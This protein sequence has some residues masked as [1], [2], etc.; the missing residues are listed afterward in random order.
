LEING[1]VNRTRTIQGSAF[2]ENFK[3]LNKIITIILEFQKSRF[4]EILSKGLPDF[5]IMINFVQALLVK[6][7]DFKTNDTVNTIPE[8]SPNLQEVQGSTYPY[9]NTYSRKRLGFYDG[10]L[11]IQIN[12]V[13]KSLYDFLLFY[14]NIYVN[15]DYFDVFNL[16]DDS[17]RDADFRRNL[18]LNPSSSVETF[19]LIVTKT[20][21]NNILSTILSSNNLNIINQIIQFFSTIRKNILELFYKIY[22][23]PPQTVGVRVSRRVA[24][25][26]FINIKDVLQYFKTLEGL[27]KVGNDIIIFEQTNIVDYL[28]HTTQTLYYNLLTQ[29]TIPDKVLRSTL[30]PPLQA[31]LNKSEEVLADESIFTIDATKDIEEDK[32]SLSLT[33]PPQPTTIAPPQVPPSSLITDSINN[34]SSKVIKKQRLRE[35]RQQQQ[36]DKAR[37]TK[38]YYTRLQVAKNLIGSYV[39]S[40]NI[41]RKIKPNVAGDTNRSLG[42]LYEITD[43]HLLVALKILFKREVPYLT[44]IGI[45]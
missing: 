35:E 6:L 32:R 27:F 40:R 23:Q 5:Q 4:D 18:G 13:Y 12:G 20:N 45:K 36:I 9:P 44:M 38:R 28:D 3:G 30:E 42:F 26:V 16:D 19:K 8:L 2:Y 31:N 43:L 15:M 39:R 1:T 22:I 21:M 14:N 11:Y 7:N 17:I 33:Q 24:P 41:S 34:K 10:I 37:N 29:D 25:Q